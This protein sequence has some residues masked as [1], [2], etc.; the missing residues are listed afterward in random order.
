MATFSM[1]RTPYAAV[2]PVLEVP[3]KF[4]MLVPE[5]WNVTRQEGTYELTRPGS[6]LRHMSRS[7]TG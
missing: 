1:L 5:G 4:S 7:M 3:Q 2:M 6:M